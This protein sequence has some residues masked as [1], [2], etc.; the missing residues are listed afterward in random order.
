MPSCACVCWYD[1]SIGA[2]QND[3][4]L[5]L[6]AGVIGY[7]NPSH[8]RRI[9]VY[10]YSSV[11]LSSKNLIDHLT[12][13]LCGTASEQTGA[14]VVTNTEMYIADSR[15]KLDVAVADIAPSCGWPPDSTACI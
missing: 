10:R 3:V 1:K 7:T 14:A 8:M 12:S 2:S 15:L 4:V 13:A 6:G 9:G 5:V 11:H